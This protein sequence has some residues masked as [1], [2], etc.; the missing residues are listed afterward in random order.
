MNLLKAAS[1]VFL[2]I[3][4]LCVVGFGLNYVGLFNDRFFNP[5]EEQVR[6]D[7]FECSA[8]HTDGVIRDLRE[9]R[10][11]YAHADEAGKSIIADK[12]R[13]EADE[14]TCYD[15]PSDLKS[16]SNSIR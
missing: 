8:S 9:Q 2:G 3:I 7:T 6:H 1:A 16:F 15:L 11:E 4:L 10:D 12:F 5:R 13:H 14:F